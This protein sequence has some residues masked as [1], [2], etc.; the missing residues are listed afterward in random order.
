MIKNLIVIVFVA[1]LI[2]LARAQICRKS[3]NERY[4][5][6]I[7]IWDCNSS[8]YEEL[9]L[10]LEMENIVKFD[11]G[12]RN[13]KFPMIDSSMFRNMSHLDE[14]NLV[15]C[16]VESIEENAFSNLK[17]LRKLDL[18]GNKIQELFVNVFRSLVNL[19]ELNLAN[20]L[21]EIVPVPVNLFQ[22][23]HKLTV[24]S[25]AYNR[26]DK[27]AE[28]T[29]DE[30]PGLTNLDLRNNSCIDRAYGLHWSNGSIDLEQITLDLGECN[31]NYESFLLDE[32]TTT[33]QFESI[34]STTEALEED[35]DDSMSTETKV[36]PKKPLDLGTSQ[37][38]QYSKKCSSDWLIIFSSISLI[39]SI[40]GVIA[41]HFIIQKIKKTLNEIE[42]SENLGSNRRRSHHYHSKPDTP[43]QIQRAQLK[44]LQK[45]FQSK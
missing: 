10:D 11:A 35:E 15:D 40:I 6:H 28:G 12:N 5:T 27:I 29:F 30:L 43:E 21:I 25:M 26:I 3:G 45:E 24:V 39:L 9:S 44:L 4:K 42:E 31:N 17:F 13:N 22:G 34:N 37:P 36:V 41:I 14:L 16:S 7:A 1:V 2:H 33:L 23:I 32:S 20:N 18:A 38:P 19:K 8:S